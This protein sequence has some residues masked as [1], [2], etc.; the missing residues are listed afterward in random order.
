VRVA[1]RTISLYATAKRGIASRQT[2]RNNRH[3]RW[4]FDC[5]GPLEIVAD[6]TPLSV[7]GQKQRALVAF[8]LLRA[9]EVVVRETLIDA[10]WGAEPP[11]SAWQ[12]V[13][14]YVSRLRALLREHRS[15]ARVMTRGTGYVLELELEELDLHRFEELAKEGRRAL[16]LG[17]APH[18]A[19]ALA[20]A[21]AIWRG[22]ALADLGDERF[23]SVE[24]Q[25]LEEARLAAL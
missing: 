11:D 10:L 6:S 24:R 19:T 23:V 8:L 4:S 13:A 5:S 15:H 20:D 2:P 21:L 3:R 16:Q 12:A 18:A 25:R 14:V 9:N 1:S 17:N 22:P 7:G